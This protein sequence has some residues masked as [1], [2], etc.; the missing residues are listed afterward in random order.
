MPSIINLY[1]RFLD[2]AD[3]IDTLTTYYCIHIRP[4][5]H[6]RRL[7]C[8]FV[9]MG[10]VNSCWSYQRDYESLCVPRRLQG[11]L[12]AFRIS[13]AQTFC[14]QSKDVE[15]VP[16]EET[17]RSSRVHSNTGGAIRYCVSLA[18]GWKGARNVEARLSLNAPS[19]MSTTTL[20]RTSTALVNSASKGQGVQRMTIQ[21]VKKLSLTPLLQLVFSCSYSVNSR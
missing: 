10:I 20:T 11:D 18:S 12:L 9:D 7:L 19:T 15:R 4:E 17:W 16:E 14:K 3:A 6:Y 21:S 1:K 8:H 2:N 13:I 5:K